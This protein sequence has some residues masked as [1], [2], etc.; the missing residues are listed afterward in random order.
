M[1]R[2]PMYS[3][4]IFQRQRSINITVNRHTYSAQSFRESLKAKMLKQ[5]WS[6][7]VFMASLGSLQRE[8]THI[9]SRFKNND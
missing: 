7:G 1:Q 4:D 5:C 9:I 8:A 3:L 2:H 6:Q